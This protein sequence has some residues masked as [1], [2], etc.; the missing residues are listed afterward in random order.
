[1]SDNPYTSVSIAGYNASPPSDAGEKTSSN[2]LEWAKHKE[3]LGDPLKTLAEAVN[4]N[5]L[6][7]FGALVMTDDPGQENVIIAM[8]MFG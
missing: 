2:Q 4:T 5:V 8:R 1:M 3:K 7:A 6:S